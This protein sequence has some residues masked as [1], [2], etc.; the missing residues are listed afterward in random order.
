MD[1]GKTKMPEYEDDHFDRNESTQSL[2]SQ[3]GGFDI[4]VGVKKVLTTA[5]EKLYR[6]IREKNPVSR[7]G[8][9]DYMAYHYAF[10]MK[11]ATVREPETFSEA[12]KDPRWIEAMN[13]EMQALCKNE[14]WDLV[15]TH[16]A[17]RRSDADVY[18]K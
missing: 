10:M 1:K 11:V 2:D 3:F 6:S 7:F 18:T 13:E 5:N 17:K 8:Y 15:P 12:A 14:T 4:P 9:N 16:H